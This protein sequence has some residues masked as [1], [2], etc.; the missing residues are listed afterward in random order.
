MI[1]LQD[2]MTRDVIAVAPETS[3][4]EAMDT[5]TEHQVSGAP[6]V[7]GERLVGVISAADLL[8][9]ASSLPAAAMERFPEPDDA[10][11]DGPVE[12]GDG[13]SGAFF[14]DAWGAEGAPSGEYSLQSGGMPADVL[15]E[16]TV[17][18]AMTRAPLITMPPET[19]VPEAA[20]LMRRARVHRVLVLEGD[21]LVGIVTALDIVRAVADGRLTVR[22]FVFPRADAPKGRPGAQ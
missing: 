17:A 6:V 15:D 5:F 13:P 4:R 11:W 19:A 1:R 7:A 22:T 21:R 14:A 10:E 12:W 3:I 8:A 16:H 20:E 2:I 9:F 18:D